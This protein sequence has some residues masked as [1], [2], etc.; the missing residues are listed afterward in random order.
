M[1][2]AIF[3]IR[4][5]VIDVATHV[6]IWSLYFIGA[7]LFAQLSPVPGWGNDL[8]T[9][10]IALGICALAVVT[11]IIRYCIKS[12]T[13]L[14]YVFLVGAGGVWFGWPMVVSVLFWAACYSFYRDLDAVE[15]PS[16]GRKLYES[17]EYY[18]DYIALADEIYRAGLID[19]GENISSLS[20]WGP[21]WRRRE[22]KRQ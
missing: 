2:A 21:S 17:N 7:V 1:Y 19:E 10:D 14:D 18:T 15:L 11:P 9:S 12:R 13:F 20:P 4:A 8:N 16:A 5:Y 6:V 22:K 3:F